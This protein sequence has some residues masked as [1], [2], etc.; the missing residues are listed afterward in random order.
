MPAPDDLARQFRVLLDRLA[1]HERCDFDV[2]LVEQVERARDALVHAIG[3][4]GVGRL[5]G[6]AGLD[7]LRQRTACTRDRLPS[8]FKHQGD[9]DRQPSAVR[10]EGTRFSGRRRGGHASPGVRL[11]RGDASA[12]SAPVAATPAKVRRVKV[13]YLSCT[14]WSFF[15]QGGSGDPAAAVDFSVDPVTKALVAMKT[16]FCARLPRGARAGTFASARSQFRVR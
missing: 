1:D 4:E 14:T 12:A 11:R 16:I 8:G 3:E 13:W 9:A 2:V 7:R 6:K 15:L 10:P 5:I